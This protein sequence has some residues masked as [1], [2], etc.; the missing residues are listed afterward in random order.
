M[1]TRTFENAVALAEERQHLMMS[2]IDKFGMPHIAS[3]GSFECNADARIVLGDWHC[4]ATLVNLQHNS[5]VAL[6]VWDI[7][8]DRGYQFVGEVEAVR[9]SDSPIDGGDQEIVVRVSKVLDFSH[10]HHT[11]VEEETSALNLGTPADGSQ[12]PG[13]AGE[14]DQHRS[15]LYMGPLNA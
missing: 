11:D 3:V 6:V 2:T 8:T 7:V 15:Y 5:Q 1:N 9:P 13:L 4:P 12:V 14:S 10:A